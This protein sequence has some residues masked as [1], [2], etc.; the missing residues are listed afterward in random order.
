MNISGG[1][2][3]IES[4]D[5]NLLWMI[6]R[7]WLRLEK[8]ENSK[9]VLGYASLSF[10][11]LGHQSAVHPSGSVP[12][13]ECLQDTSY[14]E[15]NMKW[16][17]SSFFDDRNALLNHDVFEIVFIHYWRYDLIR[18]SIT[19]TCSELIDDY[20]EEWVGLNGSR[21]SLGIGRLAL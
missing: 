13:E 11:N 6:F 8:T 12:L 4:N 14:F 19:F 20:Y 21:P 3:E 7:A 1:M 5:I 15:A 17:S 18:W 9:K 10:P 2:T 16:F